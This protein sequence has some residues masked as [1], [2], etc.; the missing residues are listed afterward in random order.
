[1]V[2]RTSHSIACDTDEYA[3]EIQT[4]LQVTS[5]LEIMHQLP[6]MGHIYIVLHKIYIPF[7]LLNLKPVRSNIFFFFFAK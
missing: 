1:M 7:V 6:L 2:Q 4:K 5:A 3:I